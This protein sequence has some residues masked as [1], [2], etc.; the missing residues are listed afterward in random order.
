VTCHDDHSRWSQPEAR[1]GYNLVLARRGRFR[2]R[3]TVSGPTLT[4]YRFKTLRTVPG[5]GI[6]EVGYAAWQYSLITPP[7]TLRRCTG[8]SRGR[9]RIHL[10][11]P[12][13]KLRSG[14]ATDRK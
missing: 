9:D 4:V 6:H 13:E 12:R 2:R 7:S 11:G 5:L 8:A 10:K 1:D 14:A 3:P